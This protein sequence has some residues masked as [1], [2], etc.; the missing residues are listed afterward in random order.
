V[1][2]ASFSGLT[3]QVLDTLTVA[4]ILHTLTVYAPMSIQIM[5][6]GLMILITG[7]NWG[8]CGNGTGA[9]GCGDNQETFRNCADVAIV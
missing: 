8:I 6:F 4:G 9:V 5:V 3:Q 7:N 1:S 2:S